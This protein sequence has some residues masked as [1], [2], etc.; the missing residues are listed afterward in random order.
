MLYYLAEYYDIRGNKNLANRY[1]LQVQD[2]NRNYVIEWRLNEWALEKRNL[3][4][5]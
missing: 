1:F 4:S 5:F 2:L 3:G